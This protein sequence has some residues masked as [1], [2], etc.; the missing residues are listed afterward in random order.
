MSCTITKSQESPGSHTF[1]A[2]STEKPFLPN[3]MLFALLVLSLLY[4][5]P[6]DGPNLKHALPAFAL[7]AFLVSCFRPISTTL[8][9]SLLVLPS[10]QGLQLVERTSHR[11]GPFP[12]WSFGKKGFIDQS[13]IREVVIDEGIRGA[14]FRYSLAIVTDEAP[15][16]TGTGKVHIVFQKTSPRLEDLTPILNEIRSLLSLDK[17][18]T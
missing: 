3:C 10:S 18:R 4:P 9:E 6:G 5:V 11:L 7:F 17:P 15:S 12:L 1:T 13:S 2:R 8:E 14:E 16:S